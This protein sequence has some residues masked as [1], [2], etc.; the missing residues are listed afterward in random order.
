[1]R[2]KAITFVVTLTAIGRIGGAADESDSLVDS[3]RGAIVGSVRY[4]ADTK[5]PW[6]F[7][8]YYVK[9]KGQGEL[10]EAVVALRLPRSAKSPPPPQPATRVIDQ[11][12]FLF[13]PETV[14]VRTG[15]QIKFLNSDNAVHNV[16]TSHPRHAFNI[17]LPSGGEHLEPFPRASGI[18]RPFR[19]GCV[20]HSSMRAWIYVFDHPHFQLTKQD[21]KFT[22]QK[23]APGKY[24]LELA[25]P[26]GGLRW[27]QP[28]TV[29][30]GETLK[31]DIRVSP[32]DKTNSP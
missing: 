30:A 4:Q 8:R 18:G 7:A 24:K 25:H 27:S 21:G 22:L 13:T 19:I 26:A 9:R 1:M 10:A 6:R 15:D 31:I 17:N 29:K 14:A 20:Y 3:Q 28:V 16:K 5:R 12:N 23:I 11:K 32:D 2:L